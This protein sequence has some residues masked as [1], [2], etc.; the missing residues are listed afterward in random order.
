MTKSKHQIF[1]SYSGHDEFEA[2]LLQFAL[3]NS[4]GSDRVSAWTFQR[5][6]K[7]SEKEIANSLKNKVKESIATIFLV[8]PTTLKSGATQWMELAYSD[9]FDVETYVLLHHL[10]YN[11]LKNRESG[12]PPLL[13]SSQCNAATEWKTIV[14]EIDQLIKAGGN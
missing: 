13:L 11:D 6:Q 8:S 14:T 1:I 5:D 2:G 3:E 7:R 12:V 4:L 10:T 9:A